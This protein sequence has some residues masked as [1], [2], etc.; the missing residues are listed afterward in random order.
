MIT[1]DKKVR[2]LAR[3]RRIRARA[4]GT[5][6]RPRLAFFKSNKQVYAQL[7]NDDKGVTIFGT[8]SLKLDS[9]KTEKAQKIGEKVAEAAKKL[10]V[11]TVVFDRGGFAYTGITAAFADAARKGGLKF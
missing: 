2:R 9:N 1:M 3:R 7:I 10:K 11:N 5:A 6:D 8:S 4:F